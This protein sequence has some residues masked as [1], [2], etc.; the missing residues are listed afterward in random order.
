MS[1]GWTKT[2]QTLKIRSAK[3]Q[4]QKM[5]SMVIG[6]ARLLRTH[7]FTPG[8]ESSPMSLRGGGRMH[9]HTERS[10]DRVAAGLNPQDSHFEQGSFRRILTWGMALSRIPTWG[11]APS[12]LR[13]PTTGRA[14]SQDPLFRQGSLHPRIPTSGRAPSQDPL[15]RQGSFHPRIPTLDR[16]PSPG[17]P[18]Q[19]GLPP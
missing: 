14:S 12:L 17:F 18:L 5:I 3:A 2:H 7:L 13:I 6:T 11:R 19:T 8:S 9:G 4:V 15:F 1:S 10:L 16:A